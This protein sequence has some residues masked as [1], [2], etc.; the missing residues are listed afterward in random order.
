MTDITKPDSPDSSQ[1]ELSFRENAQATL[2][3]VVEAFYSHAPGDSSNAEALHELRIA[4][5]RLRYSMEFFE[6]CYGKRLNSFITAIRDLQELLGKIHDC[7]VMLEFLKTR[8]AK[9]AKREDS[10]PILLGLDRLAIEFE[11]KR[12]Q[13]ASQFDSLWRRRFGPAFKTRLLKVLGGLD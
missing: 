13:F 3:A 12:T 5:K 4:A 7:D 11:R 10:E 8:R 1:S 2:P 9:I 6:S